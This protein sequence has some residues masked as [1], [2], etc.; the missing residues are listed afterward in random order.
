MGIFAREQ[1]KRGLVAKQPLCNL[2]WFLLL[3]C[4]PFV[5]CLQTEGRK[6]NVFLRDPNSKDHTFSD[7]DGGVAAVK[8]K[9]IDKNCE[10]QQPA[11]KPAS[12]SIS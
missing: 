2:C 5:Q 11:S 1:L 4:H 10:S 8:Y 7:A 9:V 6:K 3:I 12:H